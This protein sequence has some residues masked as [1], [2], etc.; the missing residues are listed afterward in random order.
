MSPLTRMGQ[1]PPRRNRRPARR[2][3]KRR[4]LLQHQRQ[5]RHLQP[6]HLRCRLSHPQRRR[7]NDRADEGKASLPAFPYAG[8]VGVGARV[9]SLSPRAHLGSTPLCENPCGVRRLA[10]AGA[11]QACL[12]EA[13]AGSPQLDG[14]QAPLALSG[15]KPPH[16]T[17]IIRASW[18]GLNKDCPSNHHNGRLDLEKNP[19][20][21]G[22]MKL[23]V[24]IHKAEEGAIG[25]KSPPSPAAPRRARRTKNCSQTSV[26]RSKVASPWIFSRPRTP[27]ITPRSWK[28]PY[29]IHFG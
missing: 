29:E 6:R 12:S 17:S 15:S 24:V 14:E 23:K 18:A 1:R 13:Y 11:G 28:S 8:Q 26:R 22:T 21:N 20:E 19:A 7:G 10:A 25:R 3:L 2:R 16:S 5:H 27:A 9:K 4:H